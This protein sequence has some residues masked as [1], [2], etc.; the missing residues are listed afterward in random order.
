MFRK[1]CAGLIALGLTTQAFAGYQMTPRQAFYYHAHKGN[2]SAL[3]KLKSMGYSVNLSDETGNSALCESVYRQDYSA[4]AMLKQVGATTAHPCVSKIPQQ[5]VQQ[6][7][8]GYANWAQAV[9]SGKIAYAGASTK[10]ATVST[11]VTTG[12]TATVATTTGLS[13]AAMV[14]ICFGAT[15]LIGGGIA[16]AAG[17]GGGG[18]SSSFTPTFVECSGRGIQD[19]DGNCNCEVGYAGGSCETCDT[20]YG[21]YG[22][23]ECHITLACEN[24]TQK[25]DVCQCNAGY[26]GTLCNTCATGYGLHGTTE[27]HKTKTC[28][29]NQHQN[30]DSC[31]CN[32]GYPV[33]YQ[34]SCYAELDCGE[35]GEQQGETCGCATGYTGD[36]CNTCDTGY[37]KYGTTDC[38]A[39]LACVNGSQ[40]GDACICT[41]NIYRGTLC[42]ECADGY[43]LYGTTTCHVTLGCVDGTQQGN[44]CVCNGNAGGTLCDA[45][46]TGYD[47]YG[48]TECH[49]TINCGANQHQNADSCVCNDGY[50]V[51]YQGACYATLVCGENEHQEGASCV[52]D[53]G[54]EKVAG[55]CT[56]TSCPANQYKSGD[57][58]LPC[59]DNSHSPA[60]STN[61]N[62][63][64]CNSGYIKSVAGV[65]VEE[66]ANASG[67]GYVYKLGVDTGYKVY[68][69]D[70]DIETNDKALEVKQNGGVAINN[71]T[72]SVGNI[73]AMTAIGKDSQVINN[74]IIDASFYQGFKYALY[75]SKAVNNGNIDV[76][77]YRNDGTLPTGQKRVIDGDSGAIL[78]NNGNIDIEMLVP[79]DGCGVIGGM[80]DLDIKVQ[81]IV[82]NGDITYTDDGVGS[83][84]D[85]L[86]ANN[87]TNNGSIKIESD[88]GTSGV[89]SDGYTVR[90]GKYIGLYSQVNE[91][92]VENPE[93]HNLITNAGLISFNL[94]GKNDDDNN[95]KEKFSAVMARGNSTITNT[96]T[97]NISIEVQDRHVYSVTGLYGTC[98][99]VSLYGESSN[100][101]NKGKISISTENTDE[102][103]VGGILSEHGR[104]FAINDGSIAILSSNHSGNQT[105][106]GILDKSKSLDYVT[107]NGTINLIGANSIVGILAAN[108]T[109]NGNIIVHAD[110]DSYSSV[111]GISGSGINNTT[112][113]ISIYSN[114][115]T[116]SGMANDEDIKGNLINKGKIH[117]SFKREALSNSLTYGSRIYGML[118]D[119]E[120]EQTCL[121]DVSGKIIVEY[122]ND[123]A[124]A[125]NRSS[126]IFGMYASE[127]N[128]LL[129]LQNDGEILVNNDTATINTV[130]SYGMYDLY[131]GKII[132][133]GDISVLSATN[134]GNTYGIL[135]NI[136][137]NRGT[138]TITSTGDGVAYGIYGKNIENRGDIV[139]N[140]SAVIGIYVSENGTF[141]NTGTITLNGTTS[142]ASC[143]TAECYLYTTDKENATATNG[144]G[145]YTNRT[146]SGTTIDPYVYT[147][148]SNYI[149][150]SS[151]ATFMT[152]GI[153]STS[154]TLNLNSFS[155]D[156][157]GKVALLDGGTL[158]APKVMGDLHIDN[159]NV[160]NGFATAYTV[161]DAI[162]S[163][164]TTELNLISDS[165]LFDATLEN[166]KDVVMTM[167][168]FDDVVDKKSLASFLEKNYTLA[169]NETFFNDIKGIGN[170][171]AL[172]SAMNSLTGQDTIARFGYEDLTAM[173]EL[174]LQMNDKM[175]SNDDKQIYKTQGNMSGF[176]FKNDNHSSVNY[177]LATKRIAPHWKIGYAMSNTT[178]GT[179]D[180]NDTTRRSSIFG[181][182]MPIGYENNGWKLISTP[183][184]AFQRSHYTRQ[185]YNDTSY[186][187]TIEKR[188]VALMNEARYPIDMTSFILTPTVEFNAIAYNQKGGEEN[189]AYALTMPSNNNL[190]VEAGIG[191]KVRK[192]FGDWKFDAGLMVYREFADPYNVKMGMQGMD[193]TFNLY[194]DNRECRGVATF[195][196][197]YD[198]DAWS[199]YGK[200][201]HF[202]E[203]DTHTN[204]KAGLKYKF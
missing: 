13:T 192:A 51:E 179:D 85:V 8:Q 100:I 12:T 62:A 186:K 121:N 193:G 94:A 15:A 167:K 131:S 133:N 49:Q 140:G 19:E 6:F 11:T 92:D 166:G 33:E 79:F 199:I 107:N 130:N 83:Y 3:Q 70:E 65:C 152:S 143:S 153:L 182:F 171:S 151:G 109:N 159:S 144:Y 158:E 203:A 82:N 170:V 168:K 148:Y 176:S 27:C 189:K 21:L 17:G 87:I 47:F 61:V 154:T 135:G 145:Y 138:I 162:I 105:I 86:V 32:D 66:R 34:G 28:G 29:M 115:G 74:G 58:C 98:S 125:N 16:L 89:T 142:N 120:N 204:M 184:I 73:S 38:H 24:G 77:F 196:F 37:G 175:F 169:N 72:I 78:Q 63:C 26:A 141:Q 30:A 18:G 71:A 23:N 156:G 44:V 2:L 128:P 202:I 124:T 59:P 108:T 81:E 7:N 136:V 126:S 48:T 201:Q 106:F 103:F 90:N 102:L 56:F 147:G 40:Q 173:R 68:N 119:G 99:N 187:G 35:H 104:S 190:S 69:N 188:T 164:D 60:G 46:K 31:V 116:L 132:N 114:E 39:T 80:N 112:G 25:G 14:G 91:D 5:T 174:N 197:D 45:C 165:A 200:V 198:V 64:V 155:P 76:I 52:C 110:A 172:K 9:N 150:L 54:Y 75:G 53:L 185:G 20:G 97:G 22:T 111:I 194:D 96:E 55:V 127:N 181:V 157:T 149:V 50:P 161:K 43:D 117:L 84:I 4:F 93:Y 191:L 195:G 41:S 163:D 123:V 129:V 118:C 160:T 42:N 183:Q 177:A 95:G 101:I 139:V 88:L 1:V 122:Q 137:E 146:G 57:G 10:A 180:D 67:S 113:E 178:L 134:A 36:M